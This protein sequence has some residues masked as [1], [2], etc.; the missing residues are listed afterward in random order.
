[1]IGNFGTKLKT[2]LSFDL[3]ICIAKYF[4]KI[5]KID[6]LYIPN[7]KFQIGVKI[8]SI[9]RIFYAS[10]CRNKNKCDF[11]YIFRS[12]RFLSKYFVRKEIKDKP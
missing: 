1:M 9:E 2:G 3:N 12:F 6:E 8:L 11:F 10:N 4:F 5:V 7:Y